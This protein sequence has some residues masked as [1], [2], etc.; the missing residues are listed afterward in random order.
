MNLTAWIMAICGPLVVRVLATLGMSVVTFTGVTV[1]VGTLISAAQT[2]WA[3]QPASVIG[4]ASLAGVPEA[5]GMV[6]G[7]YV[8]RVTL[9]AAMSATKLMFKV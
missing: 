3:G 4:L 9:W 6:C 8:A 1:V 7:A 5:L 2:Y